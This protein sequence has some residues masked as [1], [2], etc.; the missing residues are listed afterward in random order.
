MR[1]LKGFQRFCRFCWLLFANILTSLPTQFGDILLTVAV[2]NTV[3]YRFCWQS[4][5]RFPRHKPH[6]IHFPIAHIGG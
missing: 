6:N 2:D 3:Y 1:I 5:R 4:K